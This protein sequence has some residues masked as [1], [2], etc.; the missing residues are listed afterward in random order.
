ML[1][2]E[3]GKRVGIISGGCL[4]DEVAIQA[5][6]VFVSGRPLLLRYDLRRE[7]EGVL[8]YG[9]GCEGIVTVLIE[10]IAPGVNGDPLAFIQ[11]CFEEE[12][13]GRLGTIVDEN[14]PDFGKHFFVSKLPFS[15]KSKK[16]IPTSKIFWENVNPP[17]HLHV[18]GAGSDALPL[19][20]LSDELGWKTTLWDNRKLY[21]DNSGK[22]LGKNVSVRF[23]QCQPEKVGEWFGVSPRTAVV[24]MTHHFGKDQKLLASLSKFRV[25]YIGL[26]G[27]VKRGRALLDALKNENR[28]PKTKMKS[29]RTSLHSPVGLDLGSET[30]EEIALSIS[31]EV[32]VAFAGADGKTLSKI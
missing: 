2:A 18:F 28:L 19:L 4:E 21:L 5:K 29:L 16:T 6:K 10:K 25:P 14:D 11:A 20:R 27:P 12:Q 15:K 17:I 8:G 9:M 24:I 26:L 23:I 30:P 3:N 7:Q 13:T 32:Q 1:L 22:V 31:S